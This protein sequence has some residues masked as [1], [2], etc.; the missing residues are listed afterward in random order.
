M[1]INIYLNFNG[2]CAEAFDFYKTIFER[3]YNSISKYKDM[4][5]IEDVLIA[6]EHKE[7]IL[8]ISLPLNNN[9]VLM[10]CD[11]VEGLGAPLVEGNN[12]SLSIA[13]EGKDEADKHFNALTTGGQVVMPMGMTFWGS[14]FGMTIDKFGISWMISFEEKNEK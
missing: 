11:Y 8:H 3:E 6:D 2:N 14:Y 12:F 5:P 9:F 1:K 10:G 4:P 7:K 13:V